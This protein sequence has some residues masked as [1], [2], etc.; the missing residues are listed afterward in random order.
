M[1]DPTR[2]SALIH[3][4]GESSVRSQK[5]EGPSTLSKVSE[6]EVQVR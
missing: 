6:P 4:N 3:L 1:D 2:R 5:S